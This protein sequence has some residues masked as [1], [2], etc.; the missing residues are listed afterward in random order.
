MTTTNRITTKISIKPHLAEYLHKKFAV[1]GTGYIQ[2]PDSADL[3]H[4]LYD[5]LQAKTE[6]T[7]DE[8][9]KGNLE[10]A[11][12]NRPYGKNPE[13][14]NYLSERSQKIIEEK[15]DRLFKAEMHEYIDELTIDFGMTYVDSV[16]AFK[17]K[18]GLTKITDDA[19]VKDY[20]RYRR[21]I[22][23]RKKI[24]QKYTKSN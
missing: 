20:Y 2:I 9:S 23:R 13:F 21:R 7:L 19:L 10:I 6:N 1:E 12:P 11:L 16:Y 4:I 24:K 3:Y 14:Y 15:I 18:Y 8:M 5:L 17:Q 22:G